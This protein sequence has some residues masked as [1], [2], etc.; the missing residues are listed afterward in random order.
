MP[1]FAITENSSRLSEG[2]TFRLGQYLREAGTG[3]LVNC[4][5][6]ASIVQICF[7]LAPSSE[8]PLEWL[9]MKRF[10]F[11]R[12]TTLVGRGQCNNPFPQSNF[13]LL[14]SRNDPKRRGFGNHAF[15]RVGGANG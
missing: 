13:S 7:P 2:F 14:T 4:Y 9:F 6:Q 15:I 12:S 3:A 10:G 8:P 1:N 5:D 11:I